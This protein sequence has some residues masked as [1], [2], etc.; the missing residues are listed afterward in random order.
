[1]LDADLISATLG[2]AVGMALGLL[3]AGGGVIAVP[4]LILCLGFDFP[5]ARQVALLAVGGAALLGSLQGLRQGQVRYKAALLMAAV[6][7]LAS[8]LGFWLADA[9]PEQ[10]MT[11]VFCLL[12]LYLA[13]GMLRQAL[14][15]K[16][17]GDI[18]ASV[19]C[20]PCTMNVD[21]GRLR[22]NSG[23]ARSLG[24]VGA[25]AGACSGMFGVG[26]GF[27]IVPGLMRISDISMHFV[28][29]TSLAVITLV[30]SVGVLSAYAQG[31]QISALGWEFIVA[32]VFG[33]L[34]GRIWAPYISGHRLK[35]GFAA[36]QT[37]L[38]IGLFVHMI[39]VG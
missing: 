31:I 5:E 9:L 6:G 20:V 28:V 29:A 14:Q 17:A 36:A 24:W 23:C 32:A 34:A 26:G 38:S 39:W 12:M 4:A 22:W 30:S 7:G 2:A 11:T 8:P 13:W 21:T 16:T 18:H 15:E 35:L 19:V 37:L 3:G 25:A 10:F 27:L 33:L 1:M